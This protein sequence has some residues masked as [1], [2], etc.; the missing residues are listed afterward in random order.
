[1]HTR[2]SR[3]LSAGGCWLSPRQMTWKQQGPFLCMYKKAVFISRSVYHRQ[4]GYISGQQLSLCNIS[5]RN[6]FS[7]SNNNT[8]S[9][10]FVEWIAWH[11]AVT[12]G[13]I[14][15]KAKK[16][17]FPNAAFP[18]FLLTKNKGLRIKNVFSK[19]TAP[20]IISNHTLSGHL[21]T[22]YLKSKL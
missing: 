13:K 12:E 19:S 3:N 4:H 15:Y 8:K 2:Y 11:N 5:S 21:D 6:C 18:T 1:M 17:M 10:P 9:K 22:E 20:A 16:K 7:Q 14:I